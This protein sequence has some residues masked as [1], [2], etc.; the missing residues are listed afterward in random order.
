MRRGDRLARWQRGR[1]WIAPLVTGLLVALL[2]VDP[3]PL[4]PIAHAYQALCERYPHLAVLTFHTSALPLALLLSLAVLALFAGVWAGTTGLVRTCRFN[5]LLRAG[6]RAA[7]SQLVD[8]GRAFGVVD[9]LTYLDRAEPAACCYGFVRPRI[10]VTAGL[11]TRL[12]DEELAAVFAH[13]CAHLRRRDPL[14]YLMLHSLTAA[15]FMFPV[16]PALRRRVEAHI[17]LAADRSALAVTSRGAL[18]GALLTGLTAP[19]VSVPGTAGLTATEARITQ[20]TGA[21]RLPE[22]PARQTVASLGLVV[23]ITLTVVDLALAPDVVRMLCRF[24]TGA[25]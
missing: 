15:A 19:Q 14:R 2:A 6:G 22:I 21:A 12:D 23:V 11:V 17:E 13:E 18:A 4:L 24:C 20:L 3:T 10:A 7:P 1:A 5:R 8:V 25:S 9:R 16:A